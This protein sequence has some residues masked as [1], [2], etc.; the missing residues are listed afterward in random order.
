MS[1]AFARLVKIGSEQGSE[2]LFES[3]F[4]E[5]NQILKLGQENIVIEVKSGFGLIEINSKRL[6]KK[7]EK[8]LSQNPA[9]AP[10]THRVKVKIEGYIEYV[11]S[12][13]DGIGQEFTVRPD[14]VQIGEFK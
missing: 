5:L 11:S 10:A 2:S 3:L 1:W 6:A 4:Q 13:H 8:Y 12:G 14:K 9:G 7:L